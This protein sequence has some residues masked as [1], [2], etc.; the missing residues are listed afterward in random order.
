MDPDRS[1]NVDRL[2]E[3]LIALGANVQPGQIVGVFSEPGK[4]PLARSVAEAAYRRGAK[5]VDLLVFDVHVK[6]AR[7]RHAAPDTLEFVPPWY[8]DR[9]LALGRERAAVVTLTG[10]VAPHL[11]DDVDP[12][13]LGKDML[14]QLKET[15]QVLEE[16]TV[17]WTIGACPT[18]GWARVVYPDLEP[19]AALSRLWEEVGYACRLDH[20]D[21]VGAWRKR[22]DKLDSVA[23]RLDALGLRSLH[24]AGPGTDLTV[25][26]L[27]SSRWESAR[28]STADG[29]EHAPNLPTEEVFTT[30]DPERV[31]GYVT[32]TKPLFVSGGL[33]NGLRVRFEAGRAVEIDADRGAE[34]MRALTARDP[35]AARLGEVAL[36]DRESRVGTL[37]TVFYDT[38]LDENSAS[39][40]ALGHGLD[41]AVRDEADVQRINRSQLHIDFMIGGDQ[42]AVT[43][44]DGS[45]QSVPLLRDGAW[46]I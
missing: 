42:V 32:S 25:A 29:I 36:V 1:P 38:L 10:P 9:M 14:P 13:L 17:N 43:G 6:H 35:G 16:R 26:L 21:P 11:M 20:A 15:M 44:T 39:H 22:L 45:G 12:A 23:G 40:I 18:V 4:E 46:Q 30:P 34:T 2:A 37:G 31:D 7:L 24:F 3:L 41:L 28:M 27:P 5:F 19:G 33:V 8:G